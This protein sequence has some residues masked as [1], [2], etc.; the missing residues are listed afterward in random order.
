MRIKVILGDITEQDVDAIIVNLFEEVKV[1]GG[2]TGVIDKALG[3]LITNLIGDGEIRGKES[4]ITLIHTNGKIK[5][6]RVVVVGLGNKTKFTVDV[7]RS[8]SG[9][10][11]RYLANRSIKNVA[12]VVHG[13]GIGGLNP[14]DCAKAITEGAI[15]GLYK[16]DKYKSKKT[17]GSNIDKF[18]IVEVDKTKITDI[19]KSVSEGMVFAEATNLCRDLANEP[20]NIMT[21]TELSEVALNV[22][23]STGME[24]GVID[25]TKMEELGMGALLGVAQGSVQSPKLI[26]M[27]HKG[28]QANQENN[29]GLIGKGIT[30]DSGGISIKPSLKMG[31]MKGDMAGAAA[32]IAAMKAIS[33]LDLKINVIGIIAAAENMP[34]GN[35]QRPG[36]I[37][38]TMDGTTIEIE[39]T[40]AE[41]RLVLAD[42]VT[43]AKSLGLNKIV[44]VA[45]LT[46]AIA[47]ALG[48]IY[49]GAFG[50]NDELMNMV[51]SAGG[52]V[53]ENIWPMPISDK[54]I[55]QYSSTVADFKN[56]GGRL[57]GSIT[58]AQFIGEFSKDLP[59]VHLDIAA[60]S[61]SESNS[62][63]NVKGATGIT[64][65]T[66]IQ[67]A[68][69]LSE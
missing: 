66:L 14:S 13:G 64:V 44:D 58:G 36:D 41:G 9:N 26:V 34:G 8:V 20:G 46:G 60:T 12:S 35:A 2:S 15:L 25:K 19:K 5:P 23:N 61:R 49:V 50:N 27:K 38:R 29:I 67:L 18:S 65:R 56:T 37:V 59:W 1:P 28:D 48:N 4:E 63:W 55:D 30:F 54:Y 47:I 17:Q 40:D 11:C 21:P 51:V 62:G 42:A 69:G 57:A 52:S 32:V 39:N 31:D 43:Y 53:G 24:I 33:T 45:T 16:F 6:V 10:V 3:G 7:V 68:K 22:G